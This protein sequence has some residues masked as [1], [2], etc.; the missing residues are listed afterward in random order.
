MERNAMMARQD[1]T[2]QEVRRSVLDKI[3]E[4]PAVD[5]NGRPVQEPAPDELPPAPETVLPQHLE[6]YVSGDTD[7]ERAESAAVVL[8]AYNAT[9]KPAAPTRPKPDTSQGVQGSVPAPTDPLERIRNLARQTIA[10]ADTRRF[11]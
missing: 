8:A 2:L 4:L 7:Q 10:H 6:Q 9:A 11:Q 5:H 1:R 3:A